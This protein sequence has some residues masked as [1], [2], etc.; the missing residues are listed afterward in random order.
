MNSRT[1]SSVKERVKENVKEALRQN[2]WVMK[3]KTPQER[4]AYKKHLEHIA[5]ESYWAGYYGLPPTRNI[6]ERM[7]E[8]EKKFVYA[9]LT[10]RNGSKAKGR[11]KGARSEKLANARNFKAMDIGSFKQIAQ[12]TGLTVAELK[13]L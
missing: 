9:L 10:E 4:K 1:P 8:K 6:E 12:A 11:A 2:P 5:E 7:T 13:A 3:E